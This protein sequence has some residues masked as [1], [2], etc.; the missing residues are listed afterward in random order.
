[1]TDIII[2]NRSQF[3]EKRLEEVDKDSVIYKKYG[4]LFLKYQC[5]S[6]THINLFTP[7]KGNFSYKNSGN[8]NEHHNKYNNYSKKPH[9]TEDR[10]SF[11]SRKPKELSKIILGI[12]NIL[13]NE[14]YN[15]MVAK[16][17]LLKSETNIGDIIGEILDKCCLQVFYL[18]IYMRLLQDITNLCTDVEKKISVN[19]IN[20]YV[21]N[22]IDNSEWKNEYIK[23]VD[24]DEYNAFCGSQKLKS[25]LIAKNMMANRLMT[26]FELNRTVEEYASMI[27]SDLKINLEMKNENVC[28]ILIQML[29]YMSKTVKNTIK[30]LF[31][32]DCVYLYSRVN[33]CQIKFIIDEFLNIIS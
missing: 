19:S 18:N 12:L 27:I 5:F 17:R 1:M 26:M 23:T 2:I 25:R 7:P 16:I 8:G 28:I 20:K 24:E 21:D 13:N 4:E 32:I 10:N 3:Q 9:F 6:N 30:S 14:N 22:Y 31:D 33:G 11:L 29:I 15:K